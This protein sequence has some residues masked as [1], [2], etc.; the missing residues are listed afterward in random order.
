MGSH[1]PFGHLKHKLWSKERSRVKLAISLSTTKSQEST[2]DPYAQVACDMSLENSQRGLQ[3]RF[4]LHPNRRFAQEIIV[5]QSC[6]NSNL[7]DFETPI[8]ES[9]DKKSF[10]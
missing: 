4:R 9:R 3:L 5:P 1:D 6:K 8:W 7:C 2:Q 10:R